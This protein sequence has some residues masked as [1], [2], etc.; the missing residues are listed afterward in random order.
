MGHDIYLDKCYFGREPAWHMLGTGFGISTFCG[1][2]DDRVLVVNSREQSVTCNGVSYSFE[3]Y[4]HLN[5][6]SWRLFR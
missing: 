3:E 6:P 1:D 2:G 5:S 4:V